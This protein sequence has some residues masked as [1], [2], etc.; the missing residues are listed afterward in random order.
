MDAV[1]DVSQTQGQDLKSI[2]LEDDTPEM[3]IALTTLLNFS[4]VHV[5]ADVELSCDAFY[6]SE[7]MEL[8]VNPNASD[9]RAFIA[10][11]AEIAHARFH[12]RGRAFNYSRKGCK[13]TAQSVSCTLCRRFGIQREL[14]DLTGLSEHFRGWKTQDRLNMLTGIQ[15]MS[16]QIGGS[17]EKALTPPQRTGPFRHGEVR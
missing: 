15:G 12:D 14:P 11:A 9:S 17:I 16:R 6:D 4:P 7:N 10:I 8:V 1:Y 2:Q 3:E 13:F 5:V